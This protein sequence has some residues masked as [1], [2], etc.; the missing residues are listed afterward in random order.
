MQTGS[1]V[2]PWHVVHLSVR[3]PVCDVDVLNTS[4]ISSRLIS[5]GFKL[6]SADPS[7]T[8]LFQREHPH[9]SQNKNKVLEKFANEGETAR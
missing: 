2:L 9:F 1:A 3:L 7:I 4:K 8:D 5:L 6:L